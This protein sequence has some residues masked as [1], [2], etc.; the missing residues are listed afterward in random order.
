MWDEIKSVLLSEHIQKIEETAPLK[1]LFLSF[2]Y[3]NRLTKEFNVSKTYLKRYENYKWICDLNL[4][5]YFF[6]EIFKL[7]YSI[8][9]C[10]T[11]S[12]KSY[13]DERKEHFKE[14]DFVP[15]LFIDFALPE[16]TIV[17]V[18]FFFLILIKFN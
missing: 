13:W 6:L 14:K 1:F 9:N 5:I 16:I 12:W 8:R 3:F 7:L 15:L 4:V 10:V 2:R 18:S 11:I 17:Q